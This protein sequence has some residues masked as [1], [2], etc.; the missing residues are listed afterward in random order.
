[1]ADLWY[2]LGVHLAISLPSQLILPAVNDQNRGR[3][4]GGRPDDGSR[5]GEPERHLYSGMAGRPDNTE[6]R[7]TEGGRW[8]QCPTVLQPSDDD[9]RRCS[10]RPLDCAVVDG[11]IP[12]T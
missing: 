6:K 11:E 2:N 7:A 12:S 1:M 3:E 8:G 4:S 5:W 9:D 10:A